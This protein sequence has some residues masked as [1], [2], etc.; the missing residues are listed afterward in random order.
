MRLKTG[1]SFRRA[2]VATCVGAALFPL[3]AAAQTTTIAGIELTIYGTLNADFGTV[4][5]TG[6]TAST[7]PLNSLVGAPGA[8]PAEVSSRTTLRSNSSNFGLRGNRRLPG[9]MSAVFQVESAIST[10]GGTSTLSGRDTFLGIAGRFGTLLYGGNMDSPYKR[11]VQGKDPFYATGIA[12]QKGILGT[13]GFNVPSVNAVSGVTVGGNSA[14]THQNNAGFDARLNN[15]VSYRSPALAGFSGELAF[16]AR[17]QKTP[18]IDPR[19]LSLLARYESGPIFATYAHERR[20]DVFGLNGL[21][22]F[23]PGT[24]TGSGNPPTAG[25]SRDTG[26]KVGL[27]YSFGATELLVVWERLEYR[28]SVGAVSGYRR[29]ALVQSISHR[30]GVHRAIASF[31]LADD[32]KCTLA[33]GG[34]CSTDGLGAKQLSLGYDYSLDKATVLYAFWSRLRNDDAAAYNFGVSGAPAAGVGAD[35]Q[36]LALGIRYRF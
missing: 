29:D 27:G 5:R 12:T 35:P 36:A 17:E 25:N 4:E 26:N 23:V 22:G 11:S 28:T 13:P 24:G 8:A 15:L 21:L 30:F 19:V 6:A 34:D 20:E 1:S 31:G 32:G 33:S 7:G 14:A 2:A 18:S 10:D 9:D 3:A 16:G